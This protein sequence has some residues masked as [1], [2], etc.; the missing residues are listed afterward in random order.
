LG[1]EQ[2]AAP[3]A[4]FEEQRLVVPFLNVTVPVGVAPVAV[5]VVDNVTLCP[6]VVGD[7]G[8]VV[9]VVTVVVRG[10]WKLIAV[11][12]SVVFLNQSL[13]LY[14]TSI[15]PPVQACEGVNLK[16]AVVPVKSFRS[17][18]VTVQFCGR[19]TAKKSSN[20]RVASMGGLVGLLTVGMTVSV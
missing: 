20:V 11:D 7:A 15:T 4:R 19:L 8:F 1:T 17:S 14:K 13:P 5:T 18:K 16:D 12:T 9:G 6:K 3:P 2:E 10:A